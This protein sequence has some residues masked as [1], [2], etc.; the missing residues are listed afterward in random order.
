M[1]IQI[2]SMDYAVIVAYLLGIVGIGVHAGLRQKRGKSEANAE[3][4]STYFMFGWSCR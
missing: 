4:G 3:R 2:N 1:S